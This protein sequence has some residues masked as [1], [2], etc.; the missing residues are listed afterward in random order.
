MTLT[1]E[2]LK[3]ALAGEWQSIATEL[4]PSNTKN[5][6]GSTKPFYLRRIFRYGS[7]DSFE[8]EVTNFADAFGKVPLAHMHI[9]GRMEWKGDHPVAE[10]AKSVDFIADAGYEVTPLLPAFADVLNQLARDNYKTWEVNKP[11]S[12]LR[13]AFVPFGLQEGQVF[14]ECD[15]VYLFNDLLF[16]GARHV[17]ARGFDTE[18]N[19]PTNLQIPMARKK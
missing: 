18:A 8:L 15:L 5:P 14:S 6:D 10:G 4:R 19:R 12:I 3:Q 7:D 1:T 2:Q 17:D 16:W 13:K 11:Q 9:K